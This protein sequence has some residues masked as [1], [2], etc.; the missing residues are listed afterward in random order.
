M[1]SSDVQKASRKTFRQLLEM[2]IFAR[3]YNIPQ[4][5][6]DVIKR[7]QAMETV[8]NRTASLGMI[9][10]IYERLPAGD[11][12]KMTIVHTFACRRCGTE[13]E[14]REHKFT[15]SAYHDFVVDVL[16]ETRKRI[17][18]MERKPRK[19]WKDKFCDFHGHHTAAERKECKKAW[20]MERK[21]AKKALRA[22]HD[23][24]VKKR[25]T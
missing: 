11:E 8:M 7:W 6:V 24:A 10:E 15:K 3:N 25:W 14:R 2:Y 22:A 4:L 9:N 21:A 5:R 23:S 16:F 20:T 1:V 17:V 12:L 19:E 18:S 13:S